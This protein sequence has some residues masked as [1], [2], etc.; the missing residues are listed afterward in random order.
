MQ[1]NSGG[2]GYGGWGDCATTSSIS[3]FNPVGGDTTGSFVDL[4]GYSVSI[5][6]NFAIIGTPL[7]DGAF[8]DQGSASIYEFDGTHW[9]LFQKLFAPN[10]AA[11]DYFG[12]S[13]HISGDYAIIGAALDDSTH[14]N[15]GSASIYHFN[16]SSWVFMKKLIDSTGA[17]DDAFGNSVSLS[18][19]YAIVG[20]YA[21]DGTFVDQGSASIFQKIGDD[22]VFMQKI[23]H[24]TAE[25]QDNFGISVVVSGNQAMIG[26]PSYDSIYAD[27]GCVNVYQYNGSNWVLMQKIIDDTG[28]MQFAFGFSISTSGNYA[29]IGA[30]AEEVNSNQAQGSASFY[31]YG[32]GSWQFTQKITHPEGAA[33]DNLGSSLSISGNYAIIGAKDDEVGS[34]EYQGSAF[35]YARVGLGWQRLQHV[36]DPGG[37]ENDTF[38]FSSAIDGVTK[39]F[40]IGANGFVGS[41]GKAIFGKV[42]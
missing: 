35:I 42:N 2:V 34:N 13:V 15:Q 11:E 10:G 28:G 29:I 12:Y 26:T 30:P 23:I 18:G 37:N 3:E 24:S 41:S 19:N 4:F 39:R 7:D 31:R 9:V 40:V 38:G 17:N 27:Q 32:S 1:S 14:V 8:T 22:W 16:G 6:G 21:D 5:S 25:A 20:A 36:T 33:F